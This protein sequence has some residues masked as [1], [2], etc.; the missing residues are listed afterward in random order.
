M[1]RI[2]PSFFLSD[3][4]AVVIPVSLF[5][6]RRGS[7]TKSRNLFPFGSG[8]LHA[9]RLVGMTAIRKRMSRLRST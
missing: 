4:M 7:E 1:N 5:P 2:I 6:E 3:F 9:L 8:C